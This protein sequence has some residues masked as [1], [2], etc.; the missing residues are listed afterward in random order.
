MTKEKNI[1]LKNVEG[2]DTQE[3]VPEN[4]T[5]YK[6]EIPVR[7]INDVLSEMDGIAESVVVYK[8]NEKSPTRFDYIS[9][10]AILDFDL[11]VI[12]NSYGGGVYRAKFQDKHGKYRGQSM[13]SISGLFNPTVDPSIINQP[14][15]NVPLSPFRESTPL[16]EMGEIKNLLEKQTNLLALMMQNQNNP[17]TPQQSPMDMALK[18]AEIMTQNVVREPTPSFGPEKIF[19]I[20]KTGIDL[21]KNIEGGG[22]SFPEVLSQL[23][24]PVLETIQEFSKKGQATLEKVNGEEPT[25]MKK[26]NPKTFNEYLKKGLPQFIAL[27][28]NA[29]DPNLYASLMLD[30]IPQGWFEEVY[31]ICSDPKF[32]DSLVQLD[33]DVKNYETWFKEFIQS[34][35]ESL[36][37]ETVPDE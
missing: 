24:K 37:T 21:G 34:T 26:T 18:M 14:I 25:T 33:P 23:A 5:K 15:S 6:D 10:M 8:Q 13:F 29:K 7:D 1:N 2:E 30:Q 35:K 3:N 9:R 19:D 28:K 31:K 4:V 32:F 16:N 36:T 17:S 11:E 20:L 22:E 27:A 12:K